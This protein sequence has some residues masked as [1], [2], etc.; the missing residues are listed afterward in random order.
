MWMGL[1]DGVY[2]VAMTLIAI[3][4]PELASEVIDTIEKQVEITTISGILIYELIVYTATFFI[5]YELWSFHKSI[6]KLS[7]I[8]HIRQNLVN[9]LILA[10]T[11]LGAGNILLILNSKTNLASEEI[12]A[13]VS[14]ATILKDWITHG[15]ASSICM[16]LMIASMFGLMSLLARSKAN[17]E[18][19]SNLKALERSTRVKA[20][21]FLLLPLNWLPMLFGAQTP[22][23]PVGLM[24]LA[25]IAL[26]N[27]NGAK[28]RRRLS[29]T[30][31]GSS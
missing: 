22:L 16:L 15:T 14:Q 17:L 20:F 7:G 27:I 4:L 8:R 1:I 11:C 30:F 6:L 29:E 12:N 21:L 31:K 10:L 24:I 18:A 9:G 25:Y 3:E 19:I 5:L 23:A 28:L 13:G 2:A 26:S